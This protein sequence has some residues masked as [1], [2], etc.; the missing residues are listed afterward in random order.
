M[1]PG[2]IFGVNAGKVWKILSD[3]GEPLSAYK[4]MKLSELKRDQVLSGLGWLGKEGK[5]EVLEDGRY[6]LYKLV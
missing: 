2:K 6:K 3:K 4:I 1:R 5:I